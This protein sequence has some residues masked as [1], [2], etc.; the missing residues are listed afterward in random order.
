MSGDPLVNLLK[1]EFSYTNKFEELVSASIVRRIII[2]IINHYDKIALRIYL[3][4]C[5]K[6][7]L[8]STEACYENSAQS[9][10]ERLGL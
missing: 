6:Y 5:R 9:I 10:D 7:G 2:I 1:L 3:E 8:E 4:Q